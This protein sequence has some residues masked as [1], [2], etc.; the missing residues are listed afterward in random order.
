MT[1][2]RVKLYRFK[3][4]YFLAT[5]INKQLIGFQSR[6][7]VWNC[8]RLKKNTFDALLICSALVCS[9]LKGIKACTEAMHPV[10]EEPY[11]VHHDIHGCSGGPRKGRLRAAA[12]VSLLSSSLLVLSMHREILHLH[13]PK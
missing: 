3:Q 9:F 6:F 8:V 13:A 1:E 2:K 10:S 4:K 12:K 7:H 11:E 5:D